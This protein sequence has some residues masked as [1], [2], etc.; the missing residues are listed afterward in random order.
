M[1]KD[2]RPISCPN[3]GGTVVGSKCPYCGSVFWDVADLE[4]GKPAWI[5]LKHKDKIFIYKAIP[6]NISITS[7]YG[8]R[9][10][11]DIS[12]EFHAISYG[13]EVGSIYEL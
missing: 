12:M 2:I 6:E 7:I 11:M 5:R 10:T 3:C 8:S 9:P 1:T 4:I 13:K